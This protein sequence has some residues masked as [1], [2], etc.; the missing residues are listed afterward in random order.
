[1]VCVVV[2]GGALVL[3]IVLFLLS[4]QPAPLSKLPKVT[5]LIIIKIELG[6]L[7]RQLLALYLRKPFPNC[8]CWYVF[9]STD[10]LEEHSCIY[11][12]G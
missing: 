5:K 6:F 10:W 2:G 8:P 11:Q 7:E 12:Q 3:T 4:Y 1:M 9:A